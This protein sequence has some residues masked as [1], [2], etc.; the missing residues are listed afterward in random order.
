MDT[1]KLV[2]QNSRA[3]EV[4]STKIAKL[5]IRLRNCDGSAS[6][7]SATSFTKRPVLPVHASL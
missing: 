3:A 6:K 1:S 7:T 5:R 4:P 2:I